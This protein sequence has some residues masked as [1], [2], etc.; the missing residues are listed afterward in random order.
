MI[1][2]KELMYKVLWSTIEEFVGLWE[3]LWEI[4]CSPKGNLTSNREIAKKLLLYF[5]EIGLVKLFYNKWG[6]EQLHEISHQESI[7]IIKGDKFWLAPELNDLCVKI[8][9]TEKGE[10]YY[11]EE[12]IESKLD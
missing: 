12:L 10:R 2:S 8:G 5:L 9:C 4:N 3:F 11:N 6:D 7:E 1:M